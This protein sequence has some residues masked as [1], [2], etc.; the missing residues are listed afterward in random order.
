[1]WASDTPPLLR[2]LPGSWLPPGIQSAGWDTH[3]PW[4]TYLP[5]SYIYA[6]ARLPSS[7][8]LYPSAPVQDQF[9]RRGTFITSRPSHLPFPEYSKH[10]GGRT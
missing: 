2:Q 10:N 3:R 1:M 5:L 8:M 4:L 6:N 9:V 7:A